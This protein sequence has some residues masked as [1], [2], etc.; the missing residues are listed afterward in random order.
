[1]VVKR[2]E[3]GLAIHVINRGGGAALR[4]GYAMA[5]ERGVDI[6]VT[7]DADNQHHPEEIERLVRPIL[8]G[9]A[10]FVNGSR[11]LGHYGRDSSI[12][13]GGVIF[14]NY[15]LALLT[16]IKITDCSNGFRAIRT[17]CLA[18]LTLSQ[19]QYHAT[20]M[21]LECIRRGFRFLEVPITISVR[22]HGQSKKGPTVRYALGFLRTVLLTWLR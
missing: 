17:A 22:L 1:S 11:V 5:I 13:A 4:V 6:V 21:L 16:G 10:D 15:L 3:A 8:N 19:S 20:E 18:E 2:F 14:F 9:E 12:R 7:M